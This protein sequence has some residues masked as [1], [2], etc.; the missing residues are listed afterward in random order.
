MGKHCMILT[1]NINQCIEQVII[2]Y[3]HLYSYFIPNFI[4]YNNWLK[5]KS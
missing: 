3:Y 2:Q 5:G 4:E 1:P